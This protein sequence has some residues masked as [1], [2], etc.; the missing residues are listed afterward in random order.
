MII[1]LVL[2]SALLHALW[3]ALLRIEKDKDRT[4]VAA[5]CVAT[6]VSALVAGVRLGLGQVAF[7]TTLSFVW[8]VVAGVL[9][10]LYFASLAK[11][12]DRGSLGPVYTISR[13]GAIVLVWPLSIV[14]FDEPLTVLSA[15]GSGVVFGGLA[16][17][18]SRTG[19]RRKTDGSAL[20]WASACAVAIS[21]YHLAYKA[22]LRDGGGASAV[23]TVGLAVASLINLVRI[24]SEGRTVVAT[25]L[26]TRLPR[27]VLMGIVS[28]A[29]FLILI[30]ALAA[31]GA[32][33]VLTLRNTSVLFATGLAFAIGERPRRV[34]I[35]GAAC[36]A[37]GAVLMAW[38]P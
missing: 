14:V 25:L 7:A 11:A 19:D 10:W 17:A 1:A 24:G 12:L 6:L 36:V 22:A 18:S 3:N 35:L 2:F 26:R 16:L 5:V 37:A 4:L 29:S 23:F 13:G 9:E 27:I 28:A 31:G 33:Y 30:E 15:V 8:A 32:G 20:A 38:P 21:G 34:E